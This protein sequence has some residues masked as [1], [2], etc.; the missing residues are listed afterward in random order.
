MLLTIHDANLQKVA[1]IDND[2]QSTLNYYDDTWTRSLET[3]SSTF[4]FTVYKKAIKS[5]TSTS[6]TYNL[7]NERAF[8]SF[9]YHGKSYVFSVMTVEEDE[10]T[11]KCYC[12]NLNL[13][14]INEYANPYKAVKAMSFVEYCNAMDL[15]NFT[16]LSVGINEISDQKRTLEWDG[17]DTKLARLLSL[18]KKFDA[19]IDFDTQLN[20]DSSI[21]AFKVNVYHEND[22]SHQGVGRV[23]NDIQLTYGKNLKSITRKI[24]KTGIYNAIRPT[25]K[26]T[27]KN[28]K[29]EEV[30]EI[31]TI[32]SLGAWSEN[33]K[34][35]VREFY[36]QGDF[37]YAPLSMQM[38]PSAFTNSTTN[39][40]WIRK[41][42]EVESD[43]PSVIRAAAIANLRKNAYPALTYEVDG[44]IDVEIGDTIKIYDDGFSPI[45]LVQAR[46]SH[47]K[48]SF[49]NPVGN[50]TIFANFKA[51]ENNLSDGIQ[52]AF[53]RLFEASKPYLIKLSTDNG[54]IF[55]NQ[56]GQ[57]LVTPSLYRGGKPVVAG[58]TWRWSL[59]GNATTG[60][61]YLVQGS[62][63]TDTATL[64]V[65]AYIGNDEVAVDEISF[66]NV[67][68]GTM[69]TPGKPGQDGRTPYVHTAWANNE[70]GTSGFS[71][72]SSINKLYIGIY[73][74]F[75]PMDSTDPKKYKWTKIKGDKGDKGDP[76]QRGL[77]GLQGEKGEQ[78]LPGEKGA[79]GKTQYTHIAYANSS[80]GRT[81]FSTN[82]SNRSY[83]GMY[84]DFTS[85]DSTNPADYAWTLVKGSDGAN[86]IPGKAGTD[87]RT[88]YLHIAYAT[89]N[90]G[91]QGFSTTDSVNKTYIGTYTDYVQVDS[92]DYRVYKWTLIKGADGNGI[93][94]VTNYYLATTASTGVTR[95]TA[96]WTTTPQTITS[97]KRYH[98]NYRVELYTDGTSKTT[99]PAIIGVYGDT[100]ARGIQGIQGIRGEQGIPGEKGADGRT[101]YTHIA[102]ADNATGGGFSQ[103]DQNKAYIGMYVDF[104]V[105]DSTNPTAYR[106][107]KWKGS[108]GAQGV[109]GAKGTDGRT[110]YIH[111]AYAESADGR[112]GFSTTQTGNKRYIGTYTD[113]VQVDSA[114][115]SRY[116]WVDMVGTVKLGARNYA[117][118]Y[119]FSRGLW[120]YSQGDN[121]PRN[122]NLSNGV[123][124]LTTTTDT[125]HQ[126][127]IHS[128]SGSRLGGKADSTALLEPKAGETFTL[129]VEV[130]HNSGNPNF[131]VEI[132]D[133]GLANYNNL[134]THLYMS[135]AAT[136]EWVRYSITGKW[137][138][139]ADFGHRRIILGYSA[140]GSISFR[141]VE[142][143]QSSAFSDAGE[144]PED[145]D[146]RINS[147]ADHTLTQQQLNALSERSQIHEAELKAKASMEALSELEKAYN[148]FVK[149]NAEGQAKAEK[150]LAEAGRRIELL[151]TEFGGL[152]ELK[153][154]I[155]TFMTSSNEGLIIG[156][157]DASSTIKVSHDRISMFSAGKE[158]MYISQGVIHI[159]NG[160]FTASVQI[161]KFRTE[162]YHLNLD[163]NVIRY[164]G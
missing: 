14:L 161:G 104:T 123:Y 113:Y 17:Q 16:Y 137:K 163:M 33:N 31:V 60:M 4:E 51:L 22:D 153:T 86:G 64:T 20:A 99:E 140:I 13:E 105:T 149:A 10:Q 84:V 128:E 95:S 52:A 62:N 39:D 78:G 106:W 11:I 107:T 79:D 9:R 2:K 134:V 73:T 32:G 118:D 56:I 55:K 58:V 157:N 88:P 46:V 92:T 102:Y 136:S 42:M 26:R 34:D 82:A 120:E 18:A 74:D 121:S 44:F 133:N 5:D 145:R 6:K 111:F 112:T 146:A 94:N 30:E 119:D 50:Q 132:R 40:Q 138:S 76:G 80:D 35:G 27:V 36:Q 70:T 150:D 87:G 131:W 48:I 65:A 142:L 114:D 147:K 68:D 143:T 29:G 19:E 162:Q 41:D 71:L 109:P 81:D 63:V 23:R 159:D 129:S 160:I 66:V 21:K 141:K 103:T 24:D 54:V 49:T 115:P 110:P 57:S 144:A 122:F 139:T 25:G 38:Y 152:K 77:N 61:T 108:D 158:V 37:L 116:R 53:E 89:S 59:D 28:G 130:K 1:F 125:W 154:F 164:V 91:S 90:N 7:L 3:G 100:G 124:T 12:E 126:L 85:Q 151:I 72:D 15:L 45:L 135:Q 8:V 148:S 83:I 127:Q 117:E 156:K 93:A 75:E 97:A 155:D 98:W 67:L 43:S 96:G 47:Q 101:Q 69:G